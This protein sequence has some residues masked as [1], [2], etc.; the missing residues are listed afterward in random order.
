MAFFFGG[1][2]GGYKQGLLFWL[3]ALGC[4]VM[5]V[6]E[7]L[8]Y[9]KDPTLWEFWYVRIMGNAGFISSTLNPKL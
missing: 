4:R 8:H 5:L 7:I 9:L 2:G 6:I 3:R 1:G